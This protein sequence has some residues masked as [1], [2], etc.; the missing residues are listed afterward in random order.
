MLEWG[1][2][3]AVFG[4]AMLALIVA[5]PHLKPKAGKGGGFA[6]GLFMIFASVF[7]PARAATVEQLD[8]KKD[9]GDAEDGESGDKP[10]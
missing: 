7:D 5:L 9:I 8:R 10:S 1:I 3:A 6:V 4:V 2:A